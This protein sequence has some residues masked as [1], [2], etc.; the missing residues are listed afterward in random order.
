MRQLR[1]SIEDMRR[2]KGYYFRFAVQML[3]IFILVGYCAPHIMN[4]NTF[5]RRFSLYGDASRMYMLR[6]EWDNAKSHELMEDDTAP[7]RLLEFYSF[8]KSSPD[9]DMYTSYGYSIMV[10]AEERIEGVQ[11]EESR[12]GYAYH[13]LYVDEGFIETFRLKCVEGD[14]SFESADASDGLIPAVAGSNYGSS[15]RV[16]DVLYGEFRIVGILEKGAFYLRPGAS[17]AVFYLDDIV[18]LPLA[19]DENSDV[20]DFDMA[21][22]GSAITTDSEDVPR[23]IEEKS[24]E[25]D[26]YNLTVINYG[27]WLQ[28][29]L[30]EL[31]EEV[32]IMA[33]AVFLVLFF[34]AICMV[35][36]LLN[37]IETHRREFAIHLF[38]GARKT[39]F[40]FRIV[41]QISIP[42]IIAAA[43]SLLIY[44]EY[45]AAAY[46]V[47]P[48]GVVVLF[49]I[50]VVPIV[51]IYRQSVS[52]LLKRSE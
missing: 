15:C 41:I 23:R 9:F 49:L 42:I 44:S 38:C 32:T 50:S 27:E 52:E 19:L 26:L 14:F 16:G 24:R 13:E 18:L 10:S 36:S 12:V 51:K 8:L 17:N 5:V 34:A 28:N 3:L 20:S 4:M 40:I 37:F 46:I 35:A 45:P 31:R 21:I 1:F 22:F 33:A 6:D 48:F 25:L 2:R 7:K 29:V 43:V 30:R 11:Y 39:D 47:V